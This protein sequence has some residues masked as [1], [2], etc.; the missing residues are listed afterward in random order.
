MAVDESAKA[1]RSDA[2]HLAIALHFAGVSAGWMPTLRLPWLMLTL[3]CAVLCCAVLCCAVLC[4]AV[5]CCAVSVQSSN[6]HTTN[7]TP[8][9]TQILDIKGEEPSAGGAS[10]DI[11]ELL[12]GYGQRF[13]RVDSEVRTVGRACHP[14]GLFISL[15]CFVACFAAAQHVWWQCALTVHNA[16]QVALPLPATTTILIKTTVSTQPPQPPLPRRRQVALQY[17]ML[18][19]A[20]GGGSIELKGRLFRELLVESKDYGS[21]LGAGGPLGAGGA[22][23]AFVSGPEVRACVMKKG[24]WVGGVGGC[25]CCAAGP[26]GFVCSRSPRICLPSAAHDP[27][28]ATSSPQARQ[29]SRPRPRAPSGALR[30]AR[31]RRVR[32]P[33]QPPAR[34]GAGAVH[35]SQAPARGAAHR[36]PAAL[37]C[38]ARVQG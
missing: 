8:I 20:I 25:E 33:A 22:I 35:G 32:L 31:G 4:C 23:R 30:A 26:I 37:G 15:A 34:R 10:L 13:V 27:T 18:A 36:Q 19:A 1:L 7:P 14:S 21:L 28:R 11:P 6:P 29:P 24:E 17:Y 2:V 16:R 3:C 12:R 38:G 9:P 5:L